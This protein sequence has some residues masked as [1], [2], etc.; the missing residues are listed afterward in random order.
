MTFINYLV[1]TVGLMGITDTDLEDRPLSGL[2]RFLQNVCYFLLR[3]GYF[4]IGIHWITV[5]GKKVSTWRLMDKKSNGEVLFLIVMSRDLGLDDQFW[6]KSK[7][8]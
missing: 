2:R 6:V 8:T 3:V 5:K 7:A 1:A 4:V